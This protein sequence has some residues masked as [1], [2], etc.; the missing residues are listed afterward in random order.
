MI[1]TLF[2][3]LFLVPYFFNGQSDLI[4]PADGFIG[5]VND[6]I[7]FHWNKFH[8]SSYILELSDTPEFITIQ[9][10]ETSNNNLN[11]NLAQGEYYWR[12]QILNNSTQYSEI[13]YLN[14]LDLS[15]V[16]E[17][18]FW[19]KP[20]SGPVIG[21]D[22]SLS[23]WL[24]FYG[25][26]H[27]INENNNG[28]SLTPHSLNQF[29]TIHF[30]G[31]NT[32]VN[33]TL[34][35]YG[36]IIGVF[37]HLQIAKQQILGLHCGCANPRFI[38]SIK[39]NQAFNTGYS[40]CFSNFRVNQIN[41][42]S[43]PT[44]KWTLFSS[45]ATPKNFSK[46]Y[47]SGSHSGYGKFNG[48]ISEII[49]YKNSIQESNRILVE[50]YLRFKYSPPVNLGEDIIQDYGFCDINLSVPKYV[51]SCIWSTGETSDS[52]SVNQSGQYWV[53]CIDVFGFVS[54]DTINITLNSPNAPENTIYCP[55]STVEWNP[56]INGGE[57]SYLWSDGSES[58]INNIGSNENYFV[59][60]TDTNGCQF[61]S[62]SFLFIEDPFP[63]EVSLGNDTSVCSGNEIHFLNGYNESESF[64]WST[65]DTSQSIIIESSG[66][67]SIEAIN[68]N[69]CIGLDTIEVTV[70]GTAPSLSYSI[71]N[72]I[73][74]GSPLNFSENS[75][76]PPGNTIDQVIW[77][78]GEVDSVFSSSGAQIYQDSGL[79]AGFL[80]VTTL[81]GCSS[82][83][84]FVIEVF[85]KPIISFET[86]NYCPYEDIIFEA[87]NEYVV[88]LNSFNWNFDQDGNTSNEVS[89]SYNFGVTGNYNVE[90]ISIDSNQC[91]D[92]VVQVVF[93]QP[94]PVADIFI[95]NP[96]EFAVWDID[97][98]SSI[99]DNF[100]IATYEWNYGDETDSINP[101]QGKYYENY[102]EYSVQLILT[103]NNGC[104][105]TSIQ[106]IAVHPNPIINYQVGPACKNTWTEF[107]DLSTIPQGS[108]TE[109]NWL[110]NLQFEDTATN[111][112][113]NFPTTG[114]QLLTLRST[115]DQ[116]CIVD[117]TFTVD[118]SEEL[119]A[120]FY[121]DPQVLVSDI[122]I[123]FLNTSLGADSSYWDFGDGD[124]LNFNN[125]IEN[126][127]S[128]SN[129]L[130]GSYL[131]II[132]MTINDF[133]CRDT[134]SKTLLVN[135][136]FYDINLK[137]LFAQDING[138][139]TVGVEIENLGTIPLENLNLTLKTPEN[140][141]ILENWSGSILQ[142]E[143]EIYIF[144][145][146]PSAFISDQD[147]T[148]RFVCVEAQNAN[149]ST[150]LDINQENNTE[151][152]NI[153]GSGFALVSV[154]PNPTDE[155]LT[156]S[157]LL[158]ETSSIYVELY[159]QAGRKV[160]KNMNDDLEYGIHNFHLPL[161]LYEKGIYLMKISDGNKTEVKKIIIR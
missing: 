29:P 141:P 140:G 138:F 17:I 143:S 68:S 48:L 19:L 117:T 129:T 122:P 33:N 66:L 75:T 6:S 145:A 27:F 124:G 142:G 119:S 35:T 10:F 34:G 76:V 147:E 49:A 153:E 78:L 8:G 91:A 86:T 93:I 152:K 58:Q 42:S 158:S 104:M 110:F 5:E 139:L 3:I 80:E 100:E 135:E 51:D 52:I 47:L 116:G 81:E 144:N 31:T 96:C 26:Y 114:I 69:G 50:S 15:L 121:C 30:D 46:T 71:E 72:E 118:V 22:S 103:A 83:E 154:Y 134:I 67:Y 123:N 160:Y 113:F 107:D 25:D 126:N 77:N 2:S 36:A 128:Y 70:V 55:S 7:K 150:Y 108:L 32:L 125:N 84:N 11:I 90:L 149:I 88:P 155:D 127:I 1:K 54:R 59:T 40:T 109:T 112:S 156:I 45:S 79:Y 23:S 120:N 38:V 62:P 20:D 102:G 4:T 16:G 161:S 28:P 64:S 44:Q 95:S 56:I 131:D 101:V 133:G 151:C 57:Y 74:Q 89:P 41:S 21:P 60:I 73:C 53:E 61:T 43:V 65:T 37:K 132:L 12:V 39:N 99:S 87:S 94:A 159:D 111:T 13:R 18:Q 97:D 85:P 136:A 148:E 106:N 82:K 146:Q 24:S 14:I 63:S 157:I 137:T 105:D 98:N 115:S 130:N 9:E 92:T